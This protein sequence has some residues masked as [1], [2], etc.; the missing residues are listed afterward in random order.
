M[1]E[2]PF[3]R[4]A[5]W[6]RR[7]KHDGMTEFWRERCAAKSKPYI[8]R[9]GTVGLI[10]KVVRKWQVLGMFRVWTG[11]VWYT[12]FLILLIFSRSSGG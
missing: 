2:I 6:F 5:Y 12:K 9:L 3:R 10:S 1:R 8:C 7:A 11:R 4:Y